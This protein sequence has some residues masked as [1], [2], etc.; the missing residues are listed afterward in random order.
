[1]VSVGSARLMTSDTTGIPP[2]NGHVCLHSGSRRKIELNTVEA[3]DAHRLHLSHS[4]PGRD[5]GPSYLAV[6]EPGSDDT[7][8]RRRA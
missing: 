3:P 2:L 8:G 4:E 6:E 5:G 1:M 7:Y